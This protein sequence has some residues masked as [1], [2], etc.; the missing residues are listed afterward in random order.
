MKKI[1]VILTL[2]ICFTGCRVR[3]SEKA[4]IELEDTSIV[5]TTKKIGFVDIATHFVDSARTYV[6]SGRL[7][8]YSTDTMYF[9][10]V[11][12]NSDSCVVFDFSTS[13]PYDD[14][15]K[16]AFVGVS[17]SGSGYSYYFIGE[18]ESNHGLELISR[19]ELLY[20]GKENIYSSYNGTKMNS[21][22][23]AKLQS[24]YN[25]SSNVTYEGISANSDLAWVEENLISS[26]DAKNNVVFISKKA[27]CSY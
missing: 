5:Q 9:I 20:Y 6:N 15:W 21:E 11:G 2:I 23:S 3:L 22:I 19:D 16:Y 13:S 17:Y 26:S 7:N 10:P 25:N 12:D 18:D 1:L 8:L 14:T 27:G 24:I 4:K